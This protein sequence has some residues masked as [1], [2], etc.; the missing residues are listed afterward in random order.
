MMS[1]QEGIKEEK[2]GVVGVC[3]CV[4]VGGFVCV[5]RFCYTCEHSIFEANF[6]F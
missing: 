2:P 1:E 4:W 5:Y 3:A 6:F